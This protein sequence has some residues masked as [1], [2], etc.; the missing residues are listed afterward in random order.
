MVTFQFGFGVWWGFFGFGFFTSS[1][2]F[3]INNGTQW[4]QFEL[5]TMQLLVIK[6]EPAKGKPT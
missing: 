1:S 3:R 2:G 5:L 4:K 6:A